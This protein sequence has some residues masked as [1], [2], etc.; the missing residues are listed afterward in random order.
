[1]ASNG[2]VSDILLTEETCFK[3]MLSL[4]ADVAQMAARGGHSVNDQLIFA[5]Y[6]WNRVKSASENYFTALALISPGKNDD[7]HAK[8]HLRRQ[9][10][11]RF[12]QHFDSILKVS[13]I[14]FD[15]GDKSLQPFW[16]KTEP[17]NIL[18]P[19]HLCAQSIY[20]EVSSD[21]DLANS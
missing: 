7:R 18:S 17:P 5:V 8:T 1:V 14:L 15:L 11:N 6:I 13:H 4:I 16:Y 12:Y 19:I 20:N 9:I 10:I 3:S 21:Y 2:L